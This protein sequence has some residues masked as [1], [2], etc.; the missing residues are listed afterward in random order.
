MAMPFADECIG[1]AASPP[2]MHR[3]I[4][5]PGVTA[6]KRGSGTDIPI[7]RLAD[8]HDFIRFKETENMF[9]TAELFLKASKLRRESR[10]DHRREEYPDHDDAH[11][12]K[13][14]IF[15]CHLEEGY[16]LAEFP[17]AKYKYGPD[18]LSG[19]GEISA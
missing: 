9:L 3:Q 14:I 19:I 4:G 13:W 1:L 18:E 12:L 7:Q 8:F 15:N 16:R 2:S 6:M 11:W 5:V 17:W 10:A